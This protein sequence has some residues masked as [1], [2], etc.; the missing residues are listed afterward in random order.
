MKSDVFVRLSLFWDR[1]FA[2]IRII[3]G[4]CTIFAAYRLFQTFCRLI[5]QITFFRK[6]IFTARLPGASRTGPQGCTLLQ[7]P[8]V[9]G[10]C[11][12]CTCNFLCILLFF[13]DAKCADVL[14][15]QF[16]C[17]NAYM[18]TL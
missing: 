12:N 14:Q 1:P 4:E 9:H 3:K 8:W 5:L 7:A 13:F 17:R 15:T 11:E 10:F 2:T 16:L 6:C 18:L